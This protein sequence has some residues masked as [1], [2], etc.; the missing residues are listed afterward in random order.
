MNNQSI[1]SSE[2]DELW[3]HINKFWKLIW[4]W[5]PDG[6]KECQKYFHKLLEG[7]CFLYLYNS[8]FFILCPRKIKLNIWQKQNGNINFSS[9]NAIHSSAKYNEN[10]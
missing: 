1:N 7:K 9:V 3:F 6:M 2:I 5:N 4:R 8:T 10:M